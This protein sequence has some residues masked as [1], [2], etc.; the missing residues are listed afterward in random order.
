MTSSL[1][2]G[3]IILGFGVLTIAPS[4]AAVAV[5]KTLLY[6]CFLLVGLSAHV[7]GWQLLRATII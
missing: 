7:A 1:R 6:V 3:T 5:A 2:H 4:S